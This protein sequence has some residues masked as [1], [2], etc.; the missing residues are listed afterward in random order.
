[1]QNPESLTKALQSERHLNQYP[2]GWLI[3]GT[4]HMKLNSQKQPLAPDS[5]NCW[6]H[7]KTKL[8]IGE[9]RM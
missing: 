7:G 1:M 2:S 5:V 8:F 9:K 6:P 3:P 4:E